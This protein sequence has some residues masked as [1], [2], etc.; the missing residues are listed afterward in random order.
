M[1][2]SADDYRFMQHALRL[3]EASTRRAAPNPGV[4]CVVVKDKR[5]LGVGV[6]QS[7]G[8]DHAEIQALKQ[9][10]AHGESPV[11]ATVYVTLEPCSHYG[12]TPPCVHAL[13][14]HNVARVVVAMIDPFPAVSGRGLDRLRKAGV[15]VCAG[16][17]EQEACRI[18]RGF[19]SRIMRR[20]PWV[21]MKVAASLDGKTALSNGRSQ[22]I[23]GPDARYD[24]QHLRAEHCAILT[25][26]GTV[27]TDNPRL[28]VRDFQPVRQPLRVVV[29]SHLT[30]S[31]ACH[32]YQGG[33]TLMATT[34]RDVTRHQPWI[35]QGVTVCVLPATEAGHVDLAM[36]LSE[37]AERGVNTL[38]VEAG[39]RLNGA[40]M[41]AGLVDMIV[42]YLAPAFVGHAAQ[43]IFAWP[44]LNELTN[45]VPVVVEDVRKVGLDIRMELSLPRNE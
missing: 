14:H 27:R 39:A 5:V 31:P 1:S 34:A 30:T 33:D 29:D 8:A 20:R 7:P 28:T 16:L 37:L 42:L 45:K 11:G 6:T 38:M 3:A 25:G 43:G 12:R 2:F 40:L 13:I 15:E 26:S 19:L 9:C 21:T 4:G 18:H 41:Q 23:T 10:L 36:L 22:W 44:A 17:M 32:V 35:S 24:V